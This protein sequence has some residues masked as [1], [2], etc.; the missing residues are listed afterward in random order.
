MN[1]REKYI[2]TKDKK[3]QNTYFKTEWL[4]IEDL[5]TSKNILFF[6]TTAILCIDVEWR[7]KPNLYL[8]LRSHRSVYWPPASPS[9]PAEFK[10]YRDSRAT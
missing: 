7:I 2:Q 8:L 10:T 3:L 9:L 6:N 5:T 4:A 1:E